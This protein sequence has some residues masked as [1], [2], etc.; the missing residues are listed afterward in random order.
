[1]ENRP[2]LRNRDFRSPDIATLKRIGNAHEAISPKFTRKR[3][4]APNVFS[5]KT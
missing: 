5:R 4:E 2:E 1:M 3:M